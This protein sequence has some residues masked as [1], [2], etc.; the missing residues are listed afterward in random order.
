MAAARC[1]TASEPAARRPRGRGRARARVGRPPQPGGVAAAAAAIRIAPS[2]YAAAAPHAP[3][4]GGKTLGLS[5]ARPD[6]A[7][8]ND[9]DRP[10][11]RE[12]HER[13]PRP[14]QSRAQQ[15]SGT[16]CGDHGG[17][18]EH[19]RV[20]PGRLPNATAACASTTW[21][22]ATTS[23]SAPRSPTIASGQWRCGS[24]GI[25]RPYAG[26]TRPPGDFPARGHGTPL[27]GFLGCERG[28]AGL[29]RRPRRRLRRAARRLADSVRRQGEALDKLIRS[30]LGDAPQ[31]VLDCSCG[32][33]TQAIGLALRGH[34]V[35]ATDLSPASVD[36]RAARGGVDGR[37]AHVRGRRFHAPRRAGGGDVR[38]R[39]LVRQLGRAPALRRGSRALRREASPRSCGPAASPSSACATTTA[40][41][42]ERAAG[43]PVRCRA[44]GRSRSRSGSGTTRAAATSSRSSRCAARAR[45]G[46][47]PAAA[48]A[49]APCCA[50]SCAARSRPPGWSD[51]R[52]RTPDETGYYQPIVTARRR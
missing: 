46:R 36:A 27:N 18:A 10:D 17:H 7:A 4:M 49:C 33:G 45:A 40:L 23:G 51:V 1:R 15:P 50:T 34:D 6:H 44:R 22:Q 43:H 24:L 39:A 16:D 30:E 41:W 5:T 35:L 20:R 32:I 14:P 37:G 38:V 8:R 47:R 9:Q 2:R 28:R 3:K 13:E 42:A 26:S 31:A 29:L 12:R 25:V 21:S 48:P 52:W 19:P 11:Q